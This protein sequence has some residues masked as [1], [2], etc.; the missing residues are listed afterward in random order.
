MVCMLGTLPLV[1]A[2]QKKPARVVLPPEDEAVIRHLNAAITWYRQLA[3]ANDSAGQPSDQFYLDNAR[4]LARQALMLAF[5][6]ADAQADL[7]KPVASDASENAPSPTSTVQQ[8]IAT[9]ADKTAALITQIQSQIATLDHQIPRASG[10]RLHELM[11]KRE[12]LQEQLEFNKTLG[13]ALQKLSTF[14]TGSA[15]V[16]G[17]DLEKQVEQLK[18]SVPELLAKPAADVK[19]AEKKPAATPAAAPAHTEGTGLISQVSSLFTRLADVRQA[20]ELLDGAALVI[21]LARDVQAPLRSKM[22]ETIQAGRGLADQPPPQDEAGI[23]ANREKLQS[24]T[25]QFKQISSATIPLT[26]EVILLQN[27]QASL[28]QWQSS[29]HW[30]YIRVLES[31]LIRVAFL[32]VGIGLVLGF[33]ELWR[34]ATFRY[35]HDP[36]RRRQILLVRRTVT[37]FLMAIVIAL[38]FISEFSSLATFAG[39][40]TAGIAVAL[41]TLILSVAAY[42]FLIGRHGVRVGD[43]I[44]VSGVTGDV[45]E[46]GLVRL[47]LM[48]LGGPS[49]DL[50]P[51]GRVV[52]VSNSVLFQGV[53]FFKQIPGAAYVWHEVGLKLEKGGNY[54]VAEKK[55]LDTVNAVYADYKSTLE[56]QHRSLE[57]VAGVPIQVPAPQARLQLL[58]DV[59][60]LVVRYPVALHRET[61]IDN[62]M[63]RRI[64]ETISA[65][66]ELRA[67]AGSPSVRA[68]KT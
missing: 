54:P 9:S 57:G 67:A 55:L 31:F 49:S 65:D 5:Q 16:A 6:S 17:G 34:R 44:T 46:V 48:E 42:F 35:I 8:R 43:R 13:D 21:E 10:K 59:L 36:R 22:R 62:Q 56:Q 4:S 2:R 14:A 37:A 30:G 33:S 25:E 45:I 61:E 66:P 68:S 60:E 63:T 1:A 11:V 24:L 23:E 58:D 39:F 41:Q 32:L 3:D 50:H 51:T 12:G 29:V 64:I 27:A 26:Q 40:L 20:N 38:G 18:N 28:R 53:P 15:V 47:Y 19:A 7:Q 52:I